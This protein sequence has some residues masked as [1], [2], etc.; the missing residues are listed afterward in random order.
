MR[1]RRDALRAEIDAIMEAH[2]GIWIL[3]VQLCVDPAAMP[4]EDATAVWSTT[5]SP[6]VPVAT[7]SVPPQRSWR[8]A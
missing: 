3:S 7:L 5:L 8:A 2:G 4:I 1:G 6:F